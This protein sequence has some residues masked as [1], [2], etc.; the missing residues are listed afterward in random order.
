MNSGTRGS[1]T[2]IA[3]RA[4]PLVRR[5][6]EWRL[7]GGAT[8][9]VRRRQ[10]RPTSGHSLGAA[11]GRVRRA[12]SPDSGDAH[13][14]GVAHGAIGGGCGDIGITGPLDEMRPDGDE[15]V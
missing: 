2:R 11:V 7:D 3:R 1:G 13:L 5:V 14:R 15:A 8:P 4:S 12:A 9:L 10:P 6:G